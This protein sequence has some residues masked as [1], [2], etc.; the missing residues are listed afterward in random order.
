M[1]VRRMEPYTHQNQCHEKHLD[2]TSRNRMKPKIHIV[3]YKYLLWAYQGPI[4]EALYWLGA[5][6][7]MVG[8]IQ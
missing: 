4:M 2:A 8:P 1:I 3:M 6:L 5:V 7:Y